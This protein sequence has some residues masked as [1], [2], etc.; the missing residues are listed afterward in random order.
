[1]PSPRPTVDELVD[2]L[3]HSSLPTILVEGDD[4][5]MIYRWVEERIGIRMADAFPCGGRKTLL[6]VYARRAEFSHLKTAFVA[7]RDMWLFTAIPPEY[8]D[9][10]WTEGYSIE[11]DLYAGSNLEDLLDRDEASEHKQ[12]LR[13]LIEWFAFEVEAFRRGNEAQTDIH[14]DRIVLR[15]TVS[16]SQ[17]FVARRGYLQPNHATVMEIEA[18]YKLKLRGKTLFELLVRYLSAP[19][20]SVK[21]SIKGLYEIAFKTPKPHVYMDG[22]IGK[23]EYALSNSYLV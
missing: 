21:H 18:V 16:I 12:V 1:M 19:N 3:K 4:D 6:A 23:I 11:N 2:T 7:D 20:R 14:P 13:C 10:V 9:V 17:Q 8:S 15:G 5:M 22:L